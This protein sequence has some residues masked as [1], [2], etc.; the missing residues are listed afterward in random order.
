M[1]QESKTKEGV[2]EIEKGIFWP[3]IISVLAAVVLMIAFEAEAKKSIDAIFAL[4]T[5]QFGF[6]YIWFGAF[7]LIACLWLGFGKYGNVRFGGPDAKPEFSRA[8]WIAMFFCSG[9]GTSLIY[10]SSIEWTYYYTT[11][12]FGIEAKSQAAAEYAAMY[13][14]FHWGPIGWALYLLCAFPIGYAYYNRNQPNLRLSTACAG[15]IGEKNAKGVLGKIIDILMIF[16][17]VGGTGTSLASGTPMLAEAISQMFG[18]EHTTSVDMFVVVIWTAIFTASVTLG[19]KKGI[20]VLSDINLVAVFLLCALIL[21]FGPTFFML[22]MFTESMGLMMREFPRMA[23]Y[24]DPVGRSMFPQWWTIFY[25]AWWVAYGPYM[26]IF[27]ARISKGRTFRDLTTTVLLAGSGGCALFFMLFGNNAMHAELNNLY[28]VLDTMKDQSASAA[29]LGVLSQF[30][31]QWLIM[32]LFIFVGFIYSAT[33]VD[34]SAYS[35]AAVA[36]KDTHGGLEPMLFNRAFWAIALGGIALVLM[37]IG[38]LAP[39][40]TSSLVVGVPLVF[41][42]GISYVSLLRWLR[43][44]NKDK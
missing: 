23:F 35:L 1:S 40:K 20:K 44:D 3:G 30:K 37:K 27:I 15:V 11:P 21:V 16:G 14:I 22:N 17:L 26:G 5:D 8:S 19:L 34:S 36:S 4:V 38:G 29:I 28:P 9:I 13:G 32:P 43:E 18:I 41:L 31:M 10:W 2:A 42:M 7:A 24:T 33:T 12:P 6:V 39:L 25:W